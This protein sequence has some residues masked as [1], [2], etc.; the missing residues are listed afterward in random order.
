MENYQDASNLHMTEQDDQNKEPSTVGAQ[1]LGEQYLPNPNCHKCGQLDTSKVG[2]SKLLANRNT[3]YY[4]ISAR[5]S[6]QQ[7]GK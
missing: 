7:R 3:Q 5:I 1:I 2:D 4:G 6:L